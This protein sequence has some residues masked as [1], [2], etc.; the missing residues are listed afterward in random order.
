MR[1]IP[2][3]LLEFIVMEFYLLLTLLLSVVRLNKRHFRSLDEHDVTALP[4]NPCCLTLNFPPPH[5]ITKPLKWNV[6][7][8]KPVLFVSIKLMSEHL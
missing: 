4:N 5:P 6:G 1:L 8:K 3:C 7:P 2:S